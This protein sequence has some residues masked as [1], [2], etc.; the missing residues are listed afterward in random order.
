[1]FEA[2]VFAAVLEYACA[3]FISRQHKGILE[4]SRS[5]YFLRPARCMPSF[6]NRKHCTRIKE[7]KGV[8]SGEQIWSLSAPSDKSCVRQLTRFGKLNGLLRLSIERVFW[9]SRR[10][11][12]ISGRKRMKNGSVLYIPKETKPTTTDFKWFKIAICQ[13][14][15]RAKLQPSLAVG[16]SNRRTPF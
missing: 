4:V 16:Y 10:P 8:L 12:R 15:C 14:P 6:C 3:N 9:Q 5:P 13:S 1:M 11:S 7:M 2:Y